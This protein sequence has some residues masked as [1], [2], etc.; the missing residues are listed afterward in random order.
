[1]KPTAILYDKPECPFCWR[2]RMALHR[3]GVDYMRR[4]HDEFAHEWSLLTPGNTVPV[5][6]MS[7]VIMHDS[8]VMLEYLND[9][10]GGLWPME[11]DRCAHARSDALYADGAVGRSVRDLVFQRRDR[12]PADWDEAVIASAM[13]QWHEALPYLEERLGGDSFFVANA[14]ITDFVLASRFGLALAY[15]MPSPRLPGLSGWFE[16][17]VDRPEFLQTAPEVVIGKLERGW[18]S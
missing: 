1:M 13:Q 18:M 5:L 7:G 9:L 8:S 15:G 2:V 11:P 16:R 17:M 10:H 12:I 3:C 14:G 4:S 6:S